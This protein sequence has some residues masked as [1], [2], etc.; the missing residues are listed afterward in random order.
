VIL[1]AVP[2]ADIGDLPGGEAVLRGLA[3]CRAGVETVESLLIAI[4]A[5][6]LRRLGLAVPGSADAVVDAE[7]RLYEKLGREGV[8]DPYSRYNALLRELSSFG[9]ALEHRVFR[10]V[11]EVNS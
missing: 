1:P 8:P 4:A 2:E 6:K 11:P 7:I 10:E 3:D 5:P 9:R